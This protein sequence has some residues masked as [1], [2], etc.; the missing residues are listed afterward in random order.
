[1][2][3]DL[4]RAPSL[5]FSTLPSSISPTLSGSCSTSIQPGTCADPRGLGDDGFTESEPRTGYEH[6]KV[7]DVFNPIVTEQEIDH[8]TEESSP[9]IDDKFSSHYNQS[10][11]SSTQNSVESLATPQEADLDDEQIPDL[12]ASPTLKEKVAQG[13]LSRGSHIRKDRDMTNFQKES[14]K[15][16]FLRANESVLETLTQRM[17]QNLFL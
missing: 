16:R 7:V 2:S 15:L 8:S 10:L 14:N 3:F 1:M 4:H 17:L 11:W 9:E 5:L 12:L 13:N 6:N